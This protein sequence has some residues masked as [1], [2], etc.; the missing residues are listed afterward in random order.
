MGSPGRSG[1]PAH[2]AEERSMD[3]DVNGGLRRSRPETAVGRGPLVAYFL[4]AYA[5]TWG[6]I[7]VFLASKG[8]RF[9]EIGA[10]DALVLFPCMLVG[11][12]LSGLLLTWV[13]G[14]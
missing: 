2:P 7:L 14:G 12:S 1:P 11:P 10:T 13:V 4:L 5:L 6:L 9:S 3:A 8:F